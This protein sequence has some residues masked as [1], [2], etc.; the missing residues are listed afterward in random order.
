M[1]NSLFILIILFSFNISAQKVHKINYTGLLTLNNGTPL[2]FEMELTEK[3]GVVNGFSV[4]GKGT[5]DQTKSD[6]S[7]T[8]NRN[9]K[10]YSLKESQVLET[11]SEADLNTFCYIHMDIKEVGKFNLKR[12]EGEFIGYFTN[13]EKCA[14][15]KIVMMEKEKLEK[16]V[17][18]IKKKVNKKIEKQKKKD[19]ENIVLE[20]KILKDGDDMFIQWNSDKIIIYIWDA[21]MEDGDRINLTI[22]GKS[23]LK[24]FKTKRKR[25]KIKYKLTEGEN[26]IEI[27]ATNLGTSPPNTSRIEI[28]DSKIKY[29]I[30][31]QLELGKSAIIKIIK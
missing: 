1:R 25:K 11:N 12:M 15:G 27:I 31:T 18:K 16:K 19:K 17:K 3:G 14:T 7:G 28:I 4:T 8:Y 24:D 10:S 26:T 9:E 6:I 21:N 29:P 2:S 13:G 23:I 22:N 5:S 20:T 30:I